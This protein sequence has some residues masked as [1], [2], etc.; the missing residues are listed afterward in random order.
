MY[1]KYP[2]FFA[3]RRGKPM[4]KQQKAQKRPVKIV[5]YTSQ[6]AIEKITVMCYN[7]FEATLGADTNALF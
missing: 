1:I 2:R 7:Y 6:N 3:G 4:Q 5:K